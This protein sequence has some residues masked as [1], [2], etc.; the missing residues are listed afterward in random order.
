MLGVKQQTRRT[1]EKDRERARDDQREI[2]TERGRE[3]ERDRDGERERDSQTRSATY[4]FH[5]VGS[6]VLAEEMQQSLARH[7]HTNTA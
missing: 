1:R 5:V 6:I 4:G 7:C 2:E 3:T